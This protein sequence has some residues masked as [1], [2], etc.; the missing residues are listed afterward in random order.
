MTL[1]GPEIFVIGTPSPGCGGRYWIT[2]RLTTECGITGYGEVHASAVGPQAM[3]AV[4]PAVFH[5][6]MQGESPENIEMMFRRAYSSGFTQRP[7][8][9][10]MGAFSGLEIAAWH[11]LGKARRY[12][13]GHTWTVHACRGEPAGRRG[14]GASAP[15]VRGTRAPR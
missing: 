3:Q 10:V 11:L 2:V 8:P 12:P 1:E 15:V 7:D 14:R 4:I 13:A 6:H 5:R 9:T